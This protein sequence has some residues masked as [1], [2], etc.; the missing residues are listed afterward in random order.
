VHLLRRMSQLLALD[1]RTF[2]EQST[3]QI[4]GRP[5]AV[6]AWFLNWQLPGGLAPLTPPL[7][8]EQI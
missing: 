1:R 5:D 3:G 2:T 4:R 7:V 8:D 6:P